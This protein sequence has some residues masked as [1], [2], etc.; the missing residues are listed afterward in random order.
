MPTEIEI[1][2][3]QIEELKKKLSEARRKVEPEKVRDYDLKTADGKPIKLSVLFNGKPDLLVIHNMG[4]RCPYCTLW[5]DGFNGFTDH[6]LSRAGFALASPDEPSV[7]K[8]FAASRGWRYPVVSTHGST[9][10]KDLGFEPEPRTY[11]PGVSAFHMDE[12]GTINRTGRASFGP[13]DDFCAVWHL[14]D[15]LEN[16]ANGWEPK[17]TY[18]AEKPVAALA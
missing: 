5:A 8:Q 16:G 10:T 11:W 4:K 7:L 17:Y 2:Q 14:F 12:D 15:L 1:L 6:L 18:R 3:T 9:F 13:G